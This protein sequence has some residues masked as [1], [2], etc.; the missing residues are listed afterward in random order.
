[1]LLANG[2]LMDQES[3]RPGLGLQLGF[4]EVAGGLCVCLK[5]ASVRF[6]NI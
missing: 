1:M 2:L 6:Q 5:W 4:V 3:G